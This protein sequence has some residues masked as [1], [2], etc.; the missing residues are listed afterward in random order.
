MNGAAYL[1]KTEGILL[2]DSTLNFSS[3]TLI[4]HR[5]S[6]FAG[7]ATHFFSL[8]NLRNQHPQPDKPL[9]QSRAV[10]A[11]RDDVMSD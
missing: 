10:E 9:S 11:R 1:I 6:G 8:S 7:G 5:F 3:H 4:F 2:Q